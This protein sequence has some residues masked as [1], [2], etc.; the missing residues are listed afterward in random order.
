M[1]LL[2]SHRLTE[3]QIADAKESFGIT[4]FR[5]LPKDLQRLFSSVPP[6]LESLKV[7]AEPFKTYLKETTLEGD[8][9]LI[10][11]DFGLCFLLANFCNK[12]ALLPVYAT[13]KRIVFEKDGVKIS[14]FKHVTFRKYE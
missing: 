10:Q 7:Y 13:T 14:R 8:V 9:V 5:Y 1:H 3:E 12:E 2:F 4:Q 6:E 11:G